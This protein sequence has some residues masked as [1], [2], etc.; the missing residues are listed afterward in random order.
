MQSNRAGTAERTHLEFS[1]I[2]PTASYIT[3]TLLR[4]VKD[5]VIRQIYR[6]PDDFDR[7]SF[8]QRQR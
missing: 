3:H 5:I 6:N 7:K 2:L 4:L 1:S 8:E